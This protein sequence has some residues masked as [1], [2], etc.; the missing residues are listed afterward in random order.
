MKKLD[1]KFWEKYFRVYDILD[2]KNIF[3]LDHQANMDKK[4]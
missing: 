3:W 2:F 1:E 4:G